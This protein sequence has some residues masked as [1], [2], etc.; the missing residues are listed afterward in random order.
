MSHNKIFFSRGIISNIILKRQEKN[1]SL[2]KLSILG[3]LFRNLS[4]L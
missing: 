2:N 1:D 4:V 3:L